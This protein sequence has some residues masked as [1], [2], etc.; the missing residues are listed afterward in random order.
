[1]LFLP[2]AIE[3][4]WRQG[5]TFKVVRRKVLYTFN[6][7]FTLKQY[8]QHI[9]SLHFT[10]TRNNRVIIND[11]PIAVGVGDVMECTACLIT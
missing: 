1:M 3:E 8:K 4:N 11:C 6:T 10:R 2:L 7:P 9:F 5:T